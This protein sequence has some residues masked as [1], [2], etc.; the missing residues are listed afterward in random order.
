MKK[1]VLFA[2][3]TCDLPQEIAD[4]YNVQRLY[5][6]IT[7][8]GK[9]YIDNVTIT[10]PEMFKVYREKKVLPKTFAINSETYAEAFDRW[11]SDGYEI[12]VINISSAISACHQGAVLAAKEREGVFVVDSK[13]LSTGFGQL[14]MEA[15]EL[16]KKGVGA[17]ETANVIES[18]VPKVRTSFVLDTLEFMRAGGRCSAVAAFGANLLGLKPCIEINTDDGSLQVTKKYRGSLER[19]L[20]EYVKDQLTS[21]KNI[22][23]D[24]IFI[25]YSS[26]EPRMIAL[27]KDCIARAV[28]FDR[29]YET[30]ASCNIS[31]HC[32]PGTLGILFMT[33]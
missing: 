16:I 23:T 32:G 12:L 11:L 13:N 27:V 20:P 3:G 7:L 4:L 1:T 26:A 22:R 10:P 2:D 24:K 8:D 29:I 14:V 28:K 15:G 25:T 9:D 21:N 30:V 5:G 33:E 19:V 6:G 17:K 31:T 18:L